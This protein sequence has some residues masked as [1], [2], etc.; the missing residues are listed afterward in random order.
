MYDVYRHGE[1]DLLVLSTGSAIP[2]GYSAKKW[3]K[4]RK[5]IRKV[6]D[7][8]INCSSPRILYSS[9]AG[10]EEGANL[11]PAHRAR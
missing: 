8:Q 3:R 4:S 6:S 5:R 10:D 1:A 9:L 11:V 2:A 7:D